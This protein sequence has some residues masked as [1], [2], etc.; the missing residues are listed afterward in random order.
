MAT[1]ERVAAHQGWPLRGVPL[2]SAN[3][4]TETTTFDCTL[5]IV[6][7]M[8]TTVVCPSELVSVHDWL[9]NCV[10]NPG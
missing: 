3:D 5:L 2:Y 1:I 4:D 9:N 8:L 7:A 10:D 6:L